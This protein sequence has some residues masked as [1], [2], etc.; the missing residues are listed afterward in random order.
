MD[1][2]K[3]E[4][5]ISTRVPFIEKVSL[6]GRRG[7]KV[8]LGREREEGG[9][10][11]LVPVSRL[12]PSYQLWAE[13]RLSLAPPRRQRWVS[14]WVRKILKGGKSAC[15]AYGLFASLSYASSLAKG[16][17]EERRRGDRFVNGK[18]NADIVAR[19]CSRESE[20]YEIFFFVRGSCFFRFRN[21]KGGMDLT[22]KEE[23]FFFT[24]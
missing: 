9:E 18:L 17:E 21:R 22:E 5:V 10:G 2:S 23:L 13:G 7:R 12:P 16:T 1:S 6:A 20:N 11:D 15:A 8:R 14:P 24:E 19:F 4:L 3:I